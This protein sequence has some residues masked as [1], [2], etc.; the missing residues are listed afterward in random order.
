MQ[1]CFWSGE[2]ELIAQAAYAVVQQSKQRTGGISS[3]VVWCGSA[4]SNPGAD[5]LV[6]ELRWDQSMGVGDALSAAHSF[7]L[8]SSHHTIR[9]RTHTS[10][11]PRYLL[12][13][14]GG[15]GILAEIRSCTWHVCCIEHCG[16]SKCLKSRDGSQDNEM[17]MHGMIFCERFASE[18]R[19]Y[20]D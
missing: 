11:I 4:K 14:S 2:A 8:G 9:R 17:Q 18:L 15:V 13:G 10:L 7:V 3:T 19:S 5:A 12:L 20:M 1:R 16:A 6:S